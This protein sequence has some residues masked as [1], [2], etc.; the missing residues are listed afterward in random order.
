MV[1]VGNG[2]R[3]VRL[4]NE[5]RCGD[6]NRKQQTYL[7]EVMSILVWQERGVGWNVEVCQEKGVKS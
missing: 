3:T 2:E 1:G 7:G 6:G 5:E 4:W